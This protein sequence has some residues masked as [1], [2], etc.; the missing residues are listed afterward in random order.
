R[1]G[2]LQRRGGA[3]VVLHF[4]EKYAPALLIQFRSGLANRHLHAHLGINAHSKQGVAIE[5]RLDLFNRL[6]GRQRGH[7]VEFLDLAGTQ[8][9]AEVSQRLRDARDLRVQWLHVHVRDQSERGVN[10]CAEKTEREQ[11]ETSHKFPFVIPRSLATT[12]ERGR[13]KV[14]R[15]LCSKTSGEF[16]SL[17]VHERE[18]K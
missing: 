8:G 18:E 6:G 13:E 5:N 3:R 11:N 14:N 12:P 16:T 17:L 1:A 7:L 4:Y 15:I 2:R 10:R 9:R